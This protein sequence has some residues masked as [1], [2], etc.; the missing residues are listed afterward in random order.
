MTNTELRYKLLVLAMDIVK[1]D[2]VPPLS[3][4]KIVQTATLLKEFVF[5]E[6]SGDLDL[7]SL[8]HSDMEEYPNEILDL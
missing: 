8:D 5:A 3:P 1:H 7:E 2:D 6:N 4:I